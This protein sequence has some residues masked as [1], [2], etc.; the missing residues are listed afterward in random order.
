[1]TMILDNVSLQ[2][3]GKASHRSSGNDDRTGS[4]LVRIRTQWRREDDA[5]ENNGRIA[6]TGFRIYRAGRS[7]PA[8]MGTTG[9]GQKDGPIC[10]RL[11]AIHSVLPLW[12]RW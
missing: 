3:G 5:F 6:E 4:M 2:A 7:C 8:G 12:K 11:K 10:H 9:T 1:M